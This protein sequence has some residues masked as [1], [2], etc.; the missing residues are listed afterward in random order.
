MG[1]RMVSL[2][3][4]TILG[5]C[6][7]FFCFVD[8]ENAL[9]RKGSETSPALSFATPYLRAKEH[10]LKSLIGGGGEVVAVAHF[11]GQPCASEELLGG[12]LQ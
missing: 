11:Y 4:V 5:T 10:H 3:V 1:R 6:V 2:G 12:L 7:R 8:W 9:F